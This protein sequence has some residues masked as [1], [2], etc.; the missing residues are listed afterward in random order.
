MSDD[1]RELR[2]EVD[3]TNLLAEWQGQ[4]A[5]MLE[6]GILLADAMQ[7]EDEAK[8]ELAVVAAELEAAIRANPESYG[9]AKLTEAAVASTIP[10]Q[11]EHAEATEAYNKARHEVRICRAAV[12]ALSHRKSTL[13]GMTDLFL[14]QWYADPTS[15]EQ[16]AE[17]REAAAKVTKRATTTKR[18][19]RR[20]NED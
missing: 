17:L 9:L 10:V 4:A 19:R 2:L 1:V 7:A 6:Y 14:R 18:R 5:M 16:P 12:D 13:Q 3:E 11:P 8:A 20:H 15:G